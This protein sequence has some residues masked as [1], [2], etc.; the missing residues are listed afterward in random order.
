[1]S[2][3]SWADHR[4]TLQLQVSKFFC[5]N[6]ECK[7]RIFTERLPKVTA[8][9]ARRTERLSEYLQVLA[10]SLGGNGGVRLARQWR[11]QISRNSLLR[12][13]SK[14]PL[15]AVGRPKQL[16]VD[17]FAFRRGQRYGTIIVDLEQRRPV[18]LLADREA[19]T[20]ADWLSDYPS[21]EV[22]SRDRSKT[23]RQGMNQGAPQAI[24]VADRF[25]LLQNLSEVLERYF[26][27]HSTV[28]KA[29]ELAYS[30]SIGA[31][32]IAPATS[33]PSRQIV[34]EERHQQRVDKHYQ[35][36]LLRQQGTPILEIA[37]QLGMGKRTVYSYLSMPSIGER[38]PKQV[39]KGSILAPYQ[40]YLVER[41][42]A[43]ERVAKQLFHEIQK[44]G[45][46][47]TYETVAR[48]IQRVAR[49]QQQVHDLSLT[50]PSSLVIS[51]KHRPLTARR[52]SWLVLQPM[53]K[54][55]S[56]NQDLLEHMRQQPELSPAIRLAQSFATLVRDRLGSRLDDWLE[57]ASKSSMKA[58]EG[59]ASSL[60]DD[61][62]AVKAGVTM[63]TSNG[64]V[65]GQINRLKTLKRQMYG[66]AGIDLL[67]RRFLNV[68]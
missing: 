11:Y 50:Q 13:L 17:D 67:R 7:R 60:R 3:L 19:Q 52:A 43:G 56:A 45:Y 22:L 61:Y 24:Q 64:Q 20:L 29:A 42:N 30:Q 39:N 54:L 48:F 34:T 58:F 46:G 68:A 63:E 12:L 26:R 4:V 44:Q 53:D 25:H 9:L 51:A 27:P 16:G 33:N 23:Y 6:T 57:T 40:A 2:D 66:R 8:P 28:L 41:W 32:P 55:S 14:R 10:L 31:L 15:P 62:D 49:S 1:M 47:G 59:F 37:R 35:V 38:Q 36:H 21:I 5:L 18:A 65:E